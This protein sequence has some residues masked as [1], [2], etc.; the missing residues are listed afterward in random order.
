LYQWLHDRLDRLAGFPEQMGDTIA[1]EDGAR[2]REVGIQES[3]QQ[4]QGLIHTSSTIRSG[5][6]MSV[7]TSIAGGDLPLQQ[8][9]A[10]FPDDLGQMKHTMLY[11]SIT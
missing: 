2:F 11:L 5:P 4:G 7:M 1:N 10:V 3:S 9:L 8:L 6:E